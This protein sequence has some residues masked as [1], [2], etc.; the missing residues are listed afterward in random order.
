MIW[1]PFKHI[2]I[3]NLID[4]ETFFFLLQRKNML[5]NDNVLLVSHET[6]VNKV[7]SCLST[8]IFPDKTKYPIDETMVH[9]VCNFS[10]NF[11]I[12]FSQSLC[13]TN[14]IAKS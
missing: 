10:S 11:I 9:I 5:I 2:L 12:S 14:I 3:T 1:N 4:N 7:I 13:E 8:C 6:N